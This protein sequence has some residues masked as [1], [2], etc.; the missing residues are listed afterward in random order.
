MEEGKLVRRVSKK[1]EEGQEIYQTRVDP[2]TKRDCIV[3]YHFAVEKKGVASVSIAQPTE[4][5]GS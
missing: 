1:T 4:K 3:H 2:K 5:T